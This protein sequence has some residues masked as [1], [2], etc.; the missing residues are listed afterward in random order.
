[1]FDSLLSAGLNLLGAKMGSDAAEHAADT[2]AQ[3]AREA[4]EEQ[5]RQYDLTRGDQAP[6]MEVGGQSI[7]TIG[8]LL[9]SGALFPNF[10]GEN[11][12]SEPGY[13]FRLGEGNKAIENAARARGMFMSPSTVKGLLRYGQDYASGEYQNAFNRDLTNKTTK[14][15]MLSG[16][17][18]TGQTAA[19]TLANTGANSASN[20]GQLITGA[21]NARGAA[22]IAGAN[23]WTN[24]LSNIGN[25]YNQKSF[26]DRILTNGGFSGQGINWRNTGSFNDMPMNA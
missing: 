8:D 6:W 19:N 15:N 9:R 21:G 5:K 10:T 4:I 1:V 13:Q 12:T 25:Q 3:S 22:G 16:A 2:Q 11:L 23:A 7:R 24:A 17:A 20:I 14:F 26:L 18:G